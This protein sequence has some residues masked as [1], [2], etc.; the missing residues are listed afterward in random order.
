MTIWYIHVD[1]VRRDVRQGARWLWQHPLVASVV[2]GTLAIAI[3]ATVTV[4][5]IADA[6]LF[7]PLRFP[8]A[9]RLVVAFA[10]TPARPSEPA[11]FMPYRAYLSW[12]DSARAFSSVSAAFFQG[13]T[14]RTADNAKTLVGL[15]VTPEFFSTFGMLALRGRTLEQSDAS[16]S[17]ALVISYGFWQRDL[18]GSD[19]VVGSSLILSDV[20]YTVVGIMPPDFD[21]RLLD[22]P[23]G[24]AFWTLF[25]PGDPGY[26]AGGLGPVAIVGRLRD[27]V[28]IEG[29]WSEAAVITRRAES[30][31]ELNFNQFVVNLSSLQADNTRTVRSTLL[32]VLA[33]VACLLLIA[34]MNVGVLILGRGLARRDEVALRHA[35]GAGRARLVRQF[36]AETFVLSVCGGVVGIALAYLGTRA[37]LA[38]NPLGTLPANDVLLDLRA[39]AVAMCAMVVTTVVAGLVPAIRLSAS[40][41]ADALRSGGAGGRTTPPAHRAQRAMLAAQIAASTVLLICGALLVQTSIHLR[42]EPLGFVSEDLS[43]ATV[44]LPT[45]PFDS[46]AARNRFYGLLEEQ[47]EAHPGSRAIAAATSAPLTAG[48]P[49]TVNLTAIDSTSAPRISTQDVTA[50]FFDA[51]AIPMIAGRTFDR[52]DSAQGV[53]VVVL[54]TRAATDLFGSPAQAVGQRVR[55]DQEDWREVIGVAGNVRTTFFNTLEWRTDP[56]VYRPAQQAWAR[57]GDPASTSFTLW[58]LIRS[59]RPLPAADV[60]QAVRRAGERAA[61]IEIERVPDMV[62]IATKQPTLRMTLLIWLGAVSLL[63][64]AIGVYG[65]VTQ[66]IQQRRREIA[67]RVALGAHPGAVTAGLVRSTLSAAVAGLLA[68]VGLALLLGR[69]LESLL[70]G[71]RTGDVASLAVATALLLVVTAL[72]AWA[73]AVRA[74]R[75]DAMQVL[76]D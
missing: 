43:V 19:A 47:L 28:T 69:T 8:G 30:A 74:T 27:G 34:S 11:V 39:I 37:F 52:R 51:L 58:V 7:R 63:L 76:R 56:I 38:W 53:P 29:A 62:R 71:V 57:L 41:P 61:V 60:R 14:W 31:Y 20:S 2:L 49:T 54:N 66:A 15:R 17:P 67:I 23:E 22:R 50:S 75:A 59:A 35:L 68:G 65:I 72:A 10:S 12:K 48:P 18:G 16:G 46:G 4:F 32:T 13:A 24:A 26:Q 21:V 36:L 1:D 45:T 55:L 42:T 5:S 9:D 73:P 3:G 33:A 6:W 70:F 25:R 40:A 64:A 44:V